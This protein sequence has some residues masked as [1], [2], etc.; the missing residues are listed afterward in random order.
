MRA[1]L[2]L[3]LLIVPAVACEHGDTVPV[4]V[5]MGDGTWGLAKVDRCIAPLVAALNKSGIKTLSSCCGHG[6]EGSTGRG[7]TG[8]ILCEGFLIEVHPQRT[9]D[10][11]RREYNRLFDFD[12]AMRATGISE[13][14]RRLLAPLKR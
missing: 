6:E 3:L 10:A 2:I 4:R 1:L 9:P 11:V 5:L 7:K 12:A 14:P 8:Y 13:W